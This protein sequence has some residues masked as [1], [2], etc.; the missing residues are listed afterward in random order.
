LDHEDKES[1]PNSSSATY[2]I[3]IR[4]MYTEL[5]NFASLICECL[6]SPYIAECFVSNIRHFRFIILDLL[7]EFLDLHTIEP[8]E[9]HYWKDAS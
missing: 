6:N 5:L 2:V 3:Y 8:S 4:I 9:Y 7:S 1:V